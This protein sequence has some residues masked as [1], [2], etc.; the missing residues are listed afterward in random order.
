MH[1]S[2]KGRNHTEPSRHWAELQFYIKDENKPV[3]L[4]EKCLEIFLNDK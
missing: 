3:K 4:S 1:G 2:R